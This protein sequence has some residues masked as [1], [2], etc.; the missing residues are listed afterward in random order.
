MSVIWKNWIMHNLI[1]HPLAEIAS[2]VFGDK[3]WAFFHDGTLPQ[4]R[5]E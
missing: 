1:G 3:G 2:W 5:I 4:P